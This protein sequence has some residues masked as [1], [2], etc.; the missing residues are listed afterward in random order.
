LVQGTE[1]KKKKTLNWGG[2]F[3]TQGANVATIK[4]SCF[5]EIDIRGAK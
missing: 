2:Q 5:D 1:K 3:A 4:Y